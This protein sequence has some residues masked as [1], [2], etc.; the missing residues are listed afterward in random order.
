MT[1]S[2]DEMESYLGGLEIGGNNRRGCSKRT[3]WYSGHIFSTQKRQYLKS[4]YTGNFFMILQA[5]VILQFHKEIY[6]DL[7]RSF[8]CS[9]RLDYH[10]NSFVSC[11]DL[12]GC[13]WI[14]LKIYQNQKRLFIIFQ[15]TWWSSECFCQ[16]WFDDSLTILPQTVY[17]KRMAAVFQDCSILRRY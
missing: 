17:T 12:K 3:S 14:C 4:A 16:K 10:L 6:I 7:K 8:M 15:K 5:S 9:G 2:L 1:S 11:N 13:E